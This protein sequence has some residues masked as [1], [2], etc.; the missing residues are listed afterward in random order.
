MKTKLDGG[1]GVLL[2]SLLAL[3]LL[4]AAGCGKEE[5]P[6]PAAAVETAPQ[7]VAAP[8]PEPVFA[9]PA[10]ANDV[11]ANLSQVDYQVQNQN[12]EGAVDVILR[13]QIAAQQQ[14]AQLN[15]QQRLDYHNRMRLLQ[16]QIADAM[17]SGDPN[18]QRAALLLKQYNSTTT[19]GG[20]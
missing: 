8:E 2:G 18:A 3:A 14:Q 15:A 6:P 4:L 10:P 5:A 20:R 1:S 12:Y 19:R 13:A 16:K 11:Q 7:A 9:Q 17:A